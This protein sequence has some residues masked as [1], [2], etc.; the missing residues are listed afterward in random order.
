MDGETEP[1]IVP[2]V[3]RGRFVD[4]GAVGRAVGALSSEKSEGG[5]RVSASGG[6]DIA[7]VAAPIRDQD[8][9]VSAGIAKVARAEDGRA[10]YFSRSPIPFCRDA[11][12][13]FLGGGEGSSAGRTESD[14][15]AYGQESPWLRHIGIYVCRRST[16]RPGG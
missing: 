10:L 4:P 9:W 5:T 14:G 2:H 12:P 11:A 13:T 16:L 8:E 15:G 6:P 7:T 3:V 1:I